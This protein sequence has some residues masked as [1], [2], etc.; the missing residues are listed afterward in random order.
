MYHT[1]LAAVAVACA[2]STY[3][4]PSPTT[5]SKSAEISRPPKAMDVRATFPPPLGWS[6]WM[7][8]SDAGCG[9]DVCSEQQVKQVAE[10][11]M[12]NGMQKLGYEYIILD[13][14]WAAPDLIN[15]TISWDVSRFPSGMPAMSNWLHRRGFK[16][17]LY[18]S[19][20]NV[21]CSS[22]GRSKPIPGSRGR[23]NEDSAAFAMWGIDYL[24][25]D[26]CGDVKDEPWT[27]ISLHREFA[28][29]LQI[30]DPHHHILRDTVAGFWFLLGEVNEYYDMWR[31]CEDH[32]D[33]YKSIEENVACRITQ[34][35]METVANKWPYMDVL[36]TGGKG[37]APF[38]VT[39]GANAHCPAMDD[40]MYKSEFALW[41]ITQSPLFVATD[42]RFLTP[43]MREIL[44]NRDLV[45]FHQNVA[46]APG[47]FL[48]MD[49]QCG[50]FS[51]RCSI[52]KRWLDTD[53][54]L[55][56]VVLFNDHDHDNN[57]SIQLKDLGWLPIPSSAS[58]TGDTTPP[59]KLKA[60]DI[61]TGLDVP[62]SSISATAV[63]MDVPAHGAAAITI[64][65]LES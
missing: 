41:S 38:N 60:I 35:E 25:V 33:S 42:V 7:T 1:V 8:C 11:M 64:E 15:N 26:W 58:D 63:T 44:L 53:E 34:S 45:A 16:F 48:K 46:T 30:A 39:T 28:D 19:A 5:N 61:W 14:C 62:S 51:S 9:H 40:N 21:T 24:K 17:G 54:H 57:I 56:F 3:A 49:P 18:T 36:T 22:G 29:A 55:A 65:I 37:C 52:W 20:G 31:F 50:G 6:S 59:I 2:A 4:L 10:A 13:D 27:G 47:R 43:I 23:Y 12:E 32:H